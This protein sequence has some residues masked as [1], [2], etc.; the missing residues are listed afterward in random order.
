MQATAPRLLQAVFAGVGDY[1]LYLLARRLFGKSAAKW[2]V[3]R[4]QLTFGCVEKVVQLVGGSLLVLTALF[5]FYPHCALLL[6]LIVSCSAR[7]STGS[8]STAS[9]AHSATRS[10][11]VSHWPHSICGRTQADT[12]IRLTPP[13]LI[14]PLWPCCA[15]TSSAGGGRS[16]SRPS[17][18]SF[19]PPMSVRTLAVVQCSFLFSGG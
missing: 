1:S 3:R 4:T 13:P 10:N 19:G 16:S 18:S 11:A 12:R 7:S 14:R 6:R 17:S 15:G 2:T 5:N 8:C 9:R